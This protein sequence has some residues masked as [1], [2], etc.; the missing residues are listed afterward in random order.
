ME[1]EAERDPAREPAGQSHRAGVTI[2][3]GAR[4]RA[5][6]AV[7]GALHRQVHVLREQREI[8]E[9]QVHE[10]RRA[11]HAQ[12]GG[13]GQRHERAVDEGEERHAGHALAL[14][15]PHPRATRARREEVPGDERHRDER[16]PEAPAPVDHARLP[17]R[18]RA[19]R[20]HVHRRIA[21]DPPG[22]AVVL[23]VDVLPR[24]VRNPA[25]QREQVSGHGVGGA[26]RK[27][28]AVAGRVEH[29]EGAP[30]AEAEH[31]LPE[32]PQ[33]RRPKR[34][35][36]ADREP[37]RLQRHLEERARGRGPMDAVG[38]REAAMLGAVHQGRQA[39]A[40][41][42]SAV[43]RRSARPSGDGDLDVVDR[44]Q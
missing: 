17:R 21:V 44:R 13:G 41:G 42:A 33:R 6:V 32:R 26:R 40:G 16:D 11:H 14:T 3:L 8:A 18:Q 2:L 31:E 30:E 23:G 29:G 12:P 27:Q 1:V 34:E 15:P 5:H 7:A 4:H 39:I 43:N 35:R 24:P 19:A 10:R 28:R 37:R 25:R 9:R 22:P 36:D 38:L 20:D